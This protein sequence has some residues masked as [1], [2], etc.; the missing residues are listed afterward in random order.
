MVP[1]SCLRSKIIVYSKF[2]ISTFDFVFGEFRSLQQVP[3][4]LDDNRQREDHKNRKSH[5][6]DYNRQGKTTSRRLLDDN[7]QQED[8]KSDNR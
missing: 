4:V 6:R 3:T 1:Y 2:Q 5:S 8:H 7:G